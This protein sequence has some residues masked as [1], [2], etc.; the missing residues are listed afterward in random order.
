MGAA[1]TRKKNGTYPIALSAKNLLLPDVPEYARENVRKFL[2]PFLGHID[3]KVGQCWHNAQQLMTVANNPR[4]GCVEGVY[5]AT[6]A[7]ECGCECEPPAHAWNTVD[8]HLVDLTLEF[9]WATEPTLNRNWLHEPF[10]EYSF[11]EFRKYTDEVWDLDEYSITVVICDFLLA[12]DF[13]FTFTEHDREAC[14]EFNKS[15]P[16]NTS[17]EQFVFRSAADRLI[18]KRPRKTVEKEAVWG[19]SS[20]QLAGA[21]A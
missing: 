21:V 14:I 17:W 15:D 5:D 6:S 3:I 16:D 12:E 19:A 4:V 7:C 2:S 13:G 11:A 10:K 18:A 20:P 1:K 9:R 8:G